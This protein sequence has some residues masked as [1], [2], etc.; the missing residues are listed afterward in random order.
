MSIPSVTLSPLENTGSHPPISCLTQVFARPY[1][2]FNTLT[3]PHDT[4]LF[5]M[6]VITVGVR[7]SLHLTNARGPGVNQSGKLQRPFGDSNQ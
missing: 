4:L 5:S 7:A 6:L 2:S 1:M 3:Y